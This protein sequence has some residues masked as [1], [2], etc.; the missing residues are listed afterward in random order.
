MNLGPGSMDLEV[1]AH[2]LTIEKETFLEVQEELLVGIL[3]VVER[4]GTTRA[5]PSQVV[6]VRPSF[7]GDTGGS[8]E[9]ERG[10]SRGSF[11]RQFGNP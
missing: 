6:Y 7:S 2:V 8:S 3:R 1:F 11:S 10:A 9:A 4:S 5:L